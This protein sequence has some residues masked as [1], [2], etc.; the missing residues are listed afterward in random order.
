MLPTSSTL[1]I[2]SPIP[3][4][5]SLSVFHIVPFT[6]GPFLP[7]IHTDDRDRH[8]SNKVDRYNL[9]VTVLPKDRLNNY[10]QAPKT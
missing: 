9:K 3:R 5:F 8:I 10:S 1:H 4:R 6:A 7:S 2:F